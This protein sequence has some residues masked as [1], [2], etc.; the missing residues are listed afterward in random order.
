MVVST[1]IDTILTATAMF[2]GLCSRLLYHRID[3]MKIGFIYS[4][5]L[6]SGLPFIT[7][8]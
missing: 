2:I 1:A 5:T 7:C 6:S 4:V 3:E 8:I